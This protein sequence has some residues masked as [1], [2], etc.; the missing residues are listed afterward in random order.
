MSSFPSCCSSLSRSLRS[1]LSG[2]RANGEESAAPAPVLRPRR[3]VLQLCGSGDVVIGVEAGIN[4]GVWLSAGYVLL[5]LV[6]ALVGFA[7]RLI[8]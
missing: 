2:G 3:A 1:P 4:V 7:L 8:A 5:A 6:R